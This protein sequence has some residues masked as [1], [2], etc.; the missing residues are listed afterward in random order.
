MLHNIKETLVTMKDFCQL[1]SKDADLYQC[2]SKVISV[3]DTV[4]V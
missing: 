3:S 2:R 1:D 4:V